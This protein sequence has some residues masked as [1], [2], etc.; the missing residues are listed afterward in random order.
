MFNNFKNYKFSWFNVPIWLKRL[1][2]SYI[3]HIITTGR[4]RCRLKVDIIVQINN[5]G[6]GV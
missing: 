1:E 3:V 6:I 5:R 4:Q 2:S